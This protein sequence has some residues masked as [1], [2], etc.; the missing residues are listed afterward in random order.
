METVSASSRGLD[1]RQSIG[2]N[3]AAE[4]FFKRISEKNYI[5]GE[6]VFM[7]PDEVE[8]LFEKLEAA[9]AMA[10]LIDKYHGEVSLL[11]AYEAGWMK[12]DEL[13]TFKKLVFRLAL[14]DFYD[15]GLGIC[16][17]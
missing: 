11:I 16:Q 9:M 10:K 14:Y 5:E 15:F 3:V 4:A 13:T 2:F 17:H 1:V 6:V 12:I 8:N 7:S